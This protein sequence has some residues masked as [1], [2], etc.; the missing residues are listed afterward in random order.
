MATEEFS[1][2]I[3][4]VVFSVPRGMDVAPALDEVLSRVNSGILEIL[5]VEVITL[6]AEGQALRIP[7]SDAATYISG[8]LSGF[9]GA[10]SQILEEEDLAQ[11]AES[12]TGDFIAIAVIYEDRSL[13]STANLVTAAGGSVLWSGGITLDD[14]EH[15]LDA[16]PN[17]DNS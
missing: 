7:L 14:L 17:G 5:D 13:A 16:A 9:E 8:D 15:A 10:E 12:L 6:D 11:I 1:G 2:P 3:D 4:F